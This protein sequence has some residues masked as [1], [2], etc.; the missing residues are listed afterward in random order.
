V[1]STEDR[2]EVGAELNF[3]EHPLTGR[4]FFRAWSSYWSLM[5]SETDQSPPKVEKTGSQPR[6]GLWGSGAPSPAP[7]VINALLYFIFFTSSRCG[8]C[9]PLPHKTQNLCSNWKSRCRVPS[10]QC[11]LETFTNRLGLA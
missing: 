10:T 1:L 9:L 2:T 11:Q 8:F 5:G 3:D 7:E 6:L 4:P